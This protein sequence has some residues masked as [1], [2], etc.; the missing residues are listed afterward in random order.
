M[1]QQ[2]ATAVKIFRFALQQ[3]FHYDCSS[4]Q[5]LARRLSSL[6]ASTSAAPSRA[7]ATAALQPHQQ[8]LDLI[9]DHEL[10]E[11]LPVLEARLR[12]DVSKYATIHLRRGRR[13]PGSLF[14]LPGGHSPQLTA[15]AS[16]CFACLTTCAHAGRL[17]AYC[18]LSQ[19]ECKRISK[20]SPAP[21]PCT[22]RRQPRAGH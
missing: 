20:C 21:P 6:A 14:S 3:Q 10:E 8:P 9:P 4:P 18:D 19:Q 7:G 15:T 17:R 13:I 5:Q 12:P 16:V 11:G 22:R 2:T 1:G